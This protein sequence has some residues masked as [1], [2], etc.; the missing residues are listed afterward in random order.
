MT[1]KINAKCR[2]PNGSVNDIFIL[3]INEAG[4]L[5]GKGWVRMESGERV[6]IKLPGLEYRPAYVSWSEE[7]QAGFTF[8]EPLYAPV[9][10]HL[11][12][13]MKAQHPA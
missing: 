6:L 8:A 5:A 12:A 3:D 2:S 9:L 10:E 4:C 11:L 1:G 7:E 13:S